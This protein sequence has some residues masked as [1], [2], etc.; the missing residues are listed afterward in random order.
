[1][2][3][4]LQGGLESRQRFHKSLATPTTNVIDKFWHTMSTMADDTIF[5][6]YDCDCIE[7]DMASVT[8]KM[9]SQVFNVSFIL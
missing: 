8:P 2:R 3:K 4:Q 9:V 7:V 1:M 6:Y 5:L